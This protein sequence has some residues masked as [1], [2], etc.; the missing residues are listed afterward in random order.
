M[1]KEEY[2][3]AKEYFAESINLSLKT[4]GKVNPKTERY[5]N[6]IESKEL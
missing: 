4:T 2:S 6:E 3:K 1:F 5:L